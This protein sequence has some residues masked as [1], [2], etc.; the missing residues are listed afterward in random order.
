VRF[1]VALVLVALTLISVEVASAQAAPTAQAPPIV[2]MAATPDGGGYWLVAS[3]GAIFTF[4]SASFYGS[5][6]GTALNAPIVGMAATP[7]GGGYWLVASDGAIFTFGNAS[8]YGS[9]QPPADATAPETTIDSGPGGDTGTLRGVL[10]TNTTSPSFTFSASEPSTFECK[11]DAGSFRACSSGDSF[12]PL[13]NGDHTFSVRA[14]DTAGNVDATP[15]TVVFRVAACTR[16]GGAGNDAITG[17]SGSDVLCGRAGDDS[18]QPGLGADI[19]FAGTGN[20][21]VM[22]SAGN[23]GLI[24]GDGND[25]LRGGQNNDDIDGGPGNDRCDGGVGIDTA[26]NC[27]SLTAVP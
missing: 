13:G 6:G 21:T 12:G 16:S 1:L 9:R 25:S 22:P 27:E 17:T 4:G 5:L 19:V 24:G 8:F 10:Y 15:A 2:G 23:D 14:T 18:F 26:V 11:I 7:D 3:D 20:D